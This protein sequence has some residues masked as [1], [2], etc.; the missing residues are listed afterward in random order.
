M[1]I[2]LFTR[3]LSNF[4]MFGEET[5]PQFLLIREASWNHPAA[6]TKLIIFVYYVR[7]LSDQ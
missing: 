5:S 6:N 2:G 4:L 3:S 1:K 7:D